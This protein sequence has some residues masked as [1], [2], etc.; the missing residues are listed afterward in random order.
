MITS[1][2][3]LRPFSEIEI[4]KSLT[5]FKMGCNQPV[6]IRMNGRI[7]DSSVHAEVNACMRL[8]MMMKKR[9]EWVNMIVIRVVPSGKLCNSRPCRDCIT[10]LQQHMIRKGYKI[11]RVYYS[12]AENTIECESFKDMTNNLHCTYRSK[13]NVRMSPNIS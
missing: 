7:Y 11:R 9:I 13:G 6:K 2:C 12:T 8:P 10:Y 1:L 3:I 4:E 5:V